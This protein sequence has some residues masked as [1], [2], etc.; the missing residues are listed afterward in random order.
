[1]DRGVQVTP[2]DTARL[3]GI[4]ARA[5]KATPGPWKADLDV[6]DHG[7]E[8]EIVACVT[9]GPVSLLAQIGTGHLSYQENEPREGGDARWK[10][11]HASQAKV[12][13]TFIAESRSDVPWLV[14]QL[15]AAMG[16]ERDA[17]A[18][19][20]ERAAEIADRRSQRAAISDGFA[21][22]RAVVEAIRAA[23]KQR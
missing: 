13:A 21:L 11:A 7:K 3:E 2:T 12:D 20:M 17:E 5:E 6:F 19:G 14:S 4:R 23:I 8:A 9:D 10:L 1:M 18:R 15:E 16:R 22:G